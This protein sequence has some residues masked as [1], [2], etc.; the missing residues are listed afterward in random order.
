MK[1]ILLYAYGNIGRQDDGLGHALLAAAR[2]WYRENWDEKK[3]NARIFFS[4]SHQL[5]VEVVGELQNIDLVIFL[6]ASMEEALE[7]FKLR[8]VLADPQASATTTFTSH[9]VAPDFILALYQQLYG[10][11]PAAY[12]LEIRGY[13]WEFEEE[14]TEKARANLKKAWNMLRGLLEDPGKRDALM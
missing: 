1:R 12:Q 4:E 14:M 5:Q 7:D 10:K 6:D 11:G 9:S 13:D 3:Q 2:K 8:K